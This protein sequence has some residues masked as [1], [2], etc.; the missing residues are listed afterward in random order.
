VLSVTPEG[1]S[2]V[3]QSKDAWREAYAALPISEDTLIHLRHVV[4]HLEA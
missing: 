1:L 2:V 4:R 3:T